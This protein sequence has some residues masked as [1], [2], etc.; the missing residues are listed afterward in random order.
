MAVEVLTINPSRKSA[1]KK[2]AKGK[3]KMTTKRKTTKRRKTTRRKRR[4][5]SVKSAAR[6]VARRSR[7]RFFGMNFKGAL[8]GAPA[9]AAGMLACKWAAKKF[10]GVSGGGDQENWSFANYLAGAAGSVMAGFLAENLKR[11]TGQRVLEG[12]L[13]LLMYKLFM[14]EAVPNSTF[15]QEQFGE[16]EMMFLGEDG[17]PI[18][19][20][21]ENGEAWEGEG[22]EEGDLLL[23]D[24]GEIYMMGADGYTRP[25]DESHRVMAADLARRSLA[26]RNM[27]GSL[28]RPGALG[29]E[30]E[31]PGALGGQLEP[32]GTMGEMAVYPPSGAR[33]TDPYMMAYSGRG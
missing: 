16:G 4:N 17:E 26:A 8:K 29:G 18:V 20:L 33:R 1:K 3:K 9:R 5:P 32:P 21:G 11:G 19:L 23:G 28:Q 6:R 27:G 13:D 30:L 31:R 14:N 10:P 12:G 25:I 15:L 24:D 2:P 22:V 7:E